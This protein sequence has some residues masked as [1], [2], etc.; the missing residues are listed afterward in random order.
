MNREQK[1]KRDKVV[2]GQAKQK[3]TLMELQKAFSVALEMKKESR[4]HLFSHTLKHKD[5][6]IELCVFCG[7]GR[8]TTEGECEY[9]FL[10][11]IDRVQTILI[12]PQFFVGDDSQAAWIQHGDEYEDIR[13]PVE[14]EDEAAA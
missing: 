12:N 10:T 3:F 1:R 13:I 9:W 5:T 6:G 14:V 2:K 8:D 4:G 7:T 11:Y